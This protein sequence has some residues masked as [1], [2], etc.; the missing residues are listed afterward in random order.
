MPPENLSKNHPQKK[1]WNLSIPIFFELLLVF[2]TGFIDAFYLSK[3]SDSAAASVGAVLPILLF[4]ILAF[5]SIG[6]AGCHIV[7]QYI[8]ANKTNRLPSIYSALIVINL[9][10]SAIFCFGYLL[11]AD[12]ILRLI[13]LTGTILKGSQVY[14]SIIAFSLIMQAIKISLSSIIS[15]KQATEWNFY[16]SIVVCVTNLISNHLVINGAIGEE[17]IGTNGIALA[18]LLS[19]FS[20]LLVGIFTIKYYTRTKFA[21]LNYRKSE[22]LSILRLGTISSVEPISNQIFQLVITVF[23][24]KIGH[25]AL[26]ARI[27]IGNLSIFFLAWGIAITQGATILIAQNVGSKKFEQVK[28]VAKESF[29]ACSL[30]VL[31]ASAFV[32]Y[33]ANLFVGIFTESEAI[34]NISKYALF[35]NSVYMTMYLSSFFVSGVLKSTGDAKFCSIA[36]ALSQWFFGLPMVLTLCFILDFGLVGIFLGGASASTL[37]LLLNYI[38]WRSG[39]WKS[40]SLVR[41]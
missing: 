31:I 6:N 5:S 30:G 16:A 36:S 12:P 32:A 14:L 7:L 1:L 22:Y 11:L 21:F 3:I 40:M 38:R 41:E 9:L 17:Y 19:I 10:I 29:F 23:V 28:I 26:A 24:I 34:L 20:G 27:Y 18:S 13:G 33:Q 37:A 2:S 39:Q 35:A 15:S 8:G 4:P 25:D